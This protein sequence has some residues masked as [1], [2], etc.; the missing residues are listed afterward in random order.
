[1]RKNLLPDFMFLSETKNQ[2]PILEEMHEALGYENL[3]TVEPDG[4]SGGLALVYSSKFLVKFL[5]FSDRLIDLETLMIGNKIFM[6]LFYGDPVVK[7]RELVWEHLICIGISRWG[8]WFLI[9]DFNEITRHHEK[10][11]DKKRS[12][13]SF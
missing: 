3:L 8:T 13:I 4:L 1:M 6:M 5:F 11:G 7:Y 12:Y 10:E 2:R 9:G